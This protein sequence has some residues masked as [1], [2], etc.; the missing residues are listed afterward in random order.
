M[1]TFELG[2]L[3]YTNLVNSYLK[4]TKIRQNQLCD[5]FNK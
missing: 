2:M 4:D 3:Q 5:I 1:Q